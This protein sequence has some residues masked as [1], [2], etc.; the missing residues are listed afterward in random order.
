MKNS[1]FWYIHKL[2]ESP[3]WPHQ[4]LNS[5]IVVIN[6]ARPDCGA[7]NNP[8]NDRRTL[9]N[10][11]VRTSDGRLTFMIVGMATQPK[12]CAPAIQITPCLGLNC[13]SLF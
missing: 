3:L 6:F 5:A 2:P 1:H 8:T 9:A 13:F 11:E 10:T 7:C 4:E 12:R